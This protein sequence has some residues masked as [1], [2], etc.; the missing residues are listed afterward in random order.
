MYCIY[1][2][3]SRSILELILLGIV[4]ASALIDGRRSDPT[5]LYRINQTAQRQT[6]MIPCIKG[7]TEERERKERRAIVCIV[8]R[9]EENNLFMDWRGTGVV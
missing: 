5:V 3:T 4:R 2:V 7:D 9:T 8:K 1:I 6:R